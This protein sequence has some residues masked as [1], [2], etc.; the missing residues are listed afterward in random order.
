MRGDDPTDGTRGDEHRAHEHTDQGDD[1]ESERR[2]A[3]QPGSTPRITWRAERGPGWHGNQRVHSSNVKTILNREE[4][5][6]AQG[7]QRK[8][9]C[10]NGKPNLESTDPVGL[11]QSIRTCLYV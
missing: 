2:A 7:S 1:D 9:S 6:R 11:T 3:P 5:L 8:S 4:T 10:R